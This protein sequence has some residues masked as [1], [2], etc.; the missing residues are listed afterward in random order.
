MQW[1]FTKWMYCYNH[2]PDQE[3]EI[4]S[5]PL[6]ALYSHFSHEPVVVRLTTGTLLLKSVSVL[7]SA[8]HILKLE[9]YRED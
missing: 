5:S 2:Y 8:A 9:R 4:L 7:A 3:I 1:I 6:E